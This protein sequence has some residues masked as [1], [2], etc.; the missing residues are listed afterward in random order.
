MKKQSRKEM[1]KRIQEASN[2]KILRRQMELLA[3]YSRTSG[4]DQIPES[5]VAMTRL[6]RE[7]IKTKILIFVS[8]AIVAFSIA[9]CLKCI[10]VKGIQF[11]KR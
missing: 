5:S 2:K 9:H 11:I 7:L 6:Y 4:I 10:P 3:E 1:K 8:V